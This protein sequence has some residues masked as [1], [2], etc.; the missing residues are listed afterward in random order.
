MWIPS[1]ERELG[2]RVGERETT[3]DFRVLYNYLPFYFYFFT[4]GSLAHFLK[5]TYS[6]H[7]I[8]VLFK[9]QQS[10]HVSKYL[11]NCL[12]L[13]LHKPEASFVCFPF[14]AFFF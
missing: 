1:G 7:T 9:Q 4:Q 3:L 8:I 13:P 14:S 10:P 5:L 6:A 11:E 2:R 12:E